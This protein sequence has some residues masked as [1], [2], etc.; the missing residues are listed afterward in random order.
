MNKPFK[1]YNF[2]F[3]TL[4]DEKN[5]VKIEMENSQFTYD[6]IDEIKEL[7]IKKDPLFLD[8]KG[9]KESETTVSFLYEKG[10]ALKNLNAIK[11]ETYPVKVSIVEEI[12]KQDILQKYKHTDLYISLNPAT[13][14]Y[15]PMN[16][17]RYT[18]A[19]NRFMPRDMRTTLERYKACIVSILSGIA[20]EKC[21]NTPEEVRKIGNDFIK[22][23]YQQRNVSELLSLIQQ[24]NNFLTYDY[25]RSQTKRER[26]IRQKSLVTLAGISIVFLSISSLLLVKQLNQEEAL[27]SQYEAQ[28][29]QKDTLLLANEEFEKGN[30]DEAIQL[31]QEGDYEDAQLSEK[32][33]SKEQYQKAIDVHNGSLEAII[34]RLYET[35]EQQILVDLNSDFLD[36]SGKSKLEEE[37][38]I[39]QGDTNA[40][41]N[42]LNFL[43][44]ES[45]GIRLARKFIDLNDVNNAQKV[46][47]KYPEN[48]NL[49]K[50]LGIGKQIQEKTKQMNDSD[51][52]KQKETL[53]KEVDDLKEQLGEFK[54]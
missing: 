46:L 47:D 9:I 7:P 40:M 26:K 6:N 48:E 16:T 4:T 20:Y 19:A 52:E 38:G 33:I 41:V 23:I 21:L 3:G 13:L 8:F 1:I 14:Y 18:Y 24:S 17:V 27:A 29:E 2:E 25:I 11:K 36:E 45:T 22:E 44:E 5:T 34:Q 49:Q 35:K 43:T 42:T 32:L 53:Q 54:G 37:K 31:Y 10:S 15:Y 39:V 30:Y 50:L 28:L 51:D 12:L